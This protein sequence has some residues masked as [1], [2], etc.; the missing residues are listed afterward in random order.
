MRTDRVFLLQSTSPM[1]WITFLRALSLSLGATESSRSML[2][3]SAA[4]PAI[5]SKIAGREPGP[6]SWQRLGRATGAGWVRKLIFSP[7]G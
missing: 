7:F 1:A 3:T 4:L 5:F 6:N 2:M